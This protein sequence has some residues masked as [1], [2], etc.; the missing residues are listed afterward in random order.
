MPLRG[1]F[2]TEWDNDYEN[3]VK[4]I[5]FED[6]DT[7]EEVDLKLKMLECYNYRLDI[8]HKRCAYAF[9]IWLVG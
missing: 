3:K 7:D 1:E 2:E 5:A 8:R 4:D 6:G 9:V